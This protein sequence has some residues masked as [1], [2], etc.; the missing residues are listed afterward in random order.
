MNRRSILQWLL[1]GLAALFGGRLFRRA[2]LPDGF[3]RLSEAYF[4]EPGV[5]IGL[6]LA[7]EDAPLV[8]TIVWTGRIVRQPEPFFGQIEKVVSDGI[9]PC[10]VRSASPGTPERAYFDRMRCCDGCD[11]L[12]CKT[13]NRLE[14][15]ELRSREVF[16]YLLS[17]EEL[18]TDPNWQGKYDAAAP[19]VQIES[20]CARAA[21][22][23]Q[24]EACCADPLR[25]APEPP[26]HLPGPR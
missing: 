9:E 12:F 24:A 4:I 21:R 23:F 2:P 8:Q 7:E 22:R 13:A 11:N 19:F 20:P 5:P 1:A 3:R 6:T 25:Q 17:A 26:A 14:R 16:V 10:T 15:R 18:E